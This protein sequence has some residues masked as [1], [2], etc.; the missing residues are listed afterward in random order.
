MFRKC[1][2]FTQTRHIDIGRRFIIIVTTGGISKFDVSIMVGL[3]DGGGVSD[4][5]GTGIGVTVIAAVGSPQ[6]F[7]SGGDVTMLE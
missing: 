3:P 1:L 4:E 2:S 6:T 7:E 5:V